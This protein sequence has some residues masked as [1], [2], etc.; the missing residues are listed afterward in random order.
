MNIENY[1]P[2]YLYING[3]F[4]SAGK[5]EGKSV[6]NPA[7]GEMIGS[8]P[9]ATSDDLN[10]ALQSAENAF[11]DWRHSPPL[12]RSSILREAANIIRKRANLIARNLTMDQG[13]PLAE[14]LKEVLS[15]ADHAD[16]HAEEARRIYGRIIPSRS[17]TV[18]Q[19]VVREPIGVCVAFTP[20]NYPFNQALRKICAAIGSG[21]TLILKGAEDSPSSVVALAQI[22]HDAGLPHGCLN[23]VW[24]DPPTISKQLIASDVTRKVSFTGSVTVGKTLA[25]LAGKHMKRTTMELGGHAPAIIFADADIENAALVLAQSKALNSGQICMSPS[26][27]YVHKN[28]LEEFTE[29]FT[30]IYSSQVQGNGLDPETTMG[31]LTQTRRVSAMEAFV[32]DAVEKGASIVTGGK[33][34]KRPGNFF[35]PTVLRNVPE[36]AR[37]MSEEPFG[38]IAPIVAF[39]DTD[40]VIKNAN[41]HPYGLASYVFTQS[42][43]T[44]HVA[45]TSLEAGMVTVNHFGLALPETP[46]GGVKDSGLGSEGGS[47]AFDAYLSTKF[48]TISS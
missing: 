15:A 36:T 47:E 21:C 19:M 32:S 27:F 2:L 4:I 17:P 33:A 10:T 26:R 39:I 48:I 28:V 6:Y 34:L 31:P 8:L 3:E 12:V 46:L 43:K 5:R 45:C 44:S 40:A 30:E 24:G 18:R 20:W 38:P 29:R 35:P 37:V 11:T 42:Q 9:F 1:Q 41:Q 16:W 22:F 14:A 7:T 23:V 25:A 13:K